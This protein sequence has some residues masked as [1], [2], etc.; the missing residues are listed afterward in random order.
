MNRQ[1][2]L[3]INRPAWNETDYKTEVSDLW[4]VRREK[5]TKDSDRDSQELVHST[6]SETNSENRDN[7]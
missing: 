7:A 3:D 1:L 5:T 6:I 2:E 4:S